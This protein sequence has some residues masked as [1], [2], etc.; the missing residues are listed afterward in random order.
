[1]PTSD[2]SAK[3]IKVMVG[4]E[5]MQGQAERAWRI[6]IWSMALKAKGVACK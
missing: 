2:T 5:P 3:D 1:M 4:S 6:S